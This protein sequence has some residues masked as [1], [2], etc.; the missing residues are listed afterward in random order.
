MST[1]DRRVLLVDTAIE[2]I[3]TRGLRALTHRALD[4]ELGL[5]GGS[6]SYYFRT[7]RALVEAI[8]DRITTRSRDDF[9]AAALAPTG[10]ATPEAVAE[11]IA[12]WLDRLLAER[13]AHLIARH[14][15]LLDLLDDHDLRPRLAHSLFSTE[16]A[17][18]LFQ[19]MGATDPGA[20][21]DD[22]VAVVEGAVF[23]RFAG[24]RTALRPNTPESVRQLA[25]LIGPHLS[26]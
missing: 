26:V 16:R 4:T 3:A 9:A 7:K 19:A 6:A 24:N 11:T 1:G 18:D 20:R 2:L 15:L 21:A 5:P 25:R 14:A 13:R 10:A 22:F 17:R 23:D 8:V 12:A